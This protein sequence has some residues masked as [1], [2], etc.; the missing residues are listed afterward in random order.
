MAVKEVF[1]SS[2]KG[3]T[4]DTE[5]VQMMVEMGRNGV[6]SSLTLIRSNDLFLSYFVI[7]LT[8]FHS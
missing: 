6:H 2:F 1:A 4:F 7:F 5:L 3:R 8:L